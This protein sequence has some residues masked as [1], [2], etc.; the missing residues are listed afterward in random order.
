MAATKSIV[1][2]LNHGDKLNEKNY[3]VW[4][5]KIQYLLEKQ[6]MLETIT[7]PMAEPEQG[8]TAQHR[9]DL[10]AYQAYKRKD[11]VARILMLSSMKNDLMLRFERHRSAQAVWDAVKVQYG[12]TSTTRLRQLTLKFDGYKKRQNET[13]RQ[14]LTIMSNMISELRAAGHDMTDEQQV[15]SVIRSLP[16][17]WEHM[18][19]NLTHNQNIKT[20]D[21]V[22]RHVELE[23]DRLLSEKPAN[24]AFMTESKSRGAKGSRRKN[25]KG[26]GFQ[27]GKKRN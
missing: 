27:K 10:E 12:G 17:N 16:S 22:A 9:R 11:R 26:K 25:W 4:H 7:Q 8:T 23:E 19:V 5:R 14:H 1:A 24:E 20:F 6:D 15:Q 2:D 3:D 13:M 21:D 18:R